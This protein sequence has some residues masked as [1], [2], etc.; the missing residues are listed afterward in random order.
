MNVQQF[1]ILLERLATGEIT[2]EELATLNHASREKSEWQDALNAVQDMIN[3]LGSQSSKRVTPPADFNDSLS[4]RLEGVVAD[5]P[6]RLKSLFAG[7]TAI[8]AS[9]ILFL[10]LYHPAKTVTPQPLPEQKILLSETTTTPGQPVTIT[11]DY[12]APKEIENATVVITLNGDVHFVS[13]SKKMRNKREIVWR[14]KLAKGSNLIPFTVEAPKKG[15][16]TISTKALYNSIEHP[17][18]ILLN[19]DGLQVTIFQ[20]R[21]SDRDA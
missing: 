12:I 14:G 3:L 20:Y 21:L 2:K 13:S 8:A 16:A 6:R 17:H 9:F 11:V 5:N 10:F 1:D 18:L 19:S 7:L 15:E 4:Q